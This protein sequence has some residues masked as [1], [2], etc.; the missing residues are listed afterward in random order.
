MGLTVRQVDDIDHPQH[1]DKPHRGEQ[2]ES[3]INQELI[4]NIEQFGI[5]GPAPD[6]SASRG[7]TC[8]PQN[9]GGHVLQTDPTASSF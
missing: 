9:R 5:H 7:V 1:H 8:P 6:A 4:E 3:E 2:K